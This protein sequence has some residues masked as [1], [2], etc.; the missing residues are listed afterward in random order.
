VEEVPPQRQDEA[1]GV[2]GGQTD[3]VVHAGVV[4]QRVDAPEPLDHRRHRP[5]T[6]PR[7]G[8]FRDDAAGFPIDDRRTR[9]LGRPPPNPPRPAPSAVSAR[10][11]RAR[12]PAAPP[13]TTTTLPLSRRSM[14]KSSRSAGT[15]GGRQR[16]RLDPHFTPRY[17]LHPSTP[18]GQGTQPSVLRARRLES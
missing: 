12:M 9:P 6:V 10:P 14:P 4:H 3:A 5:L 7:I 8:Q 17:S 11:P 1:L 13:V 15:R 18:G 2:T 16:P